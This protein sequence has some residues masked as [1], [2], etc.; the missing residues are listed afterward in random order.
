MHIDLEGVFR[1]FPFI[2]S[3][4]YQYLFF[5]SSTAGSLCILVILS[6]NHSQ[7][8]STLCWTLKSHLHDIT[9]YIYN[10]YYNTM[11]SLKNQTILILNQKHKLLCYM[12]RM[13]YNW[14][15]VN[16]QLS[17]LCNIHY[18]LLHNSIISVVT[19]L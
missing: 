17:I 2:C 6:K 12:W 15:I 18:H 1:L 5:F 8:T 13:K 16:I 3:L 14:T 19:Y 7:N 11:N 10:V 4:Y 9:N